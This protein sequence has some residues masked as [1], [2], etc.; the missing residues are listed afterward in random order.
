M[1]P[2]VSDRPTPPPAA[3]PLPA[4]QPLTVPEAP[5]V[6]RSFG[7]T[8]P[9]RV[10]SGNEDHFL[11][12]DLSR[13]LRVQHTSLPQESVHQGRHR[14]HVLLA[15]DGMGGHAAGEV[16]SALSVETVKAFVIDLLRRFTNLQPIDEHGVVV[17]LREAVRQADARII[18][19][20]IRRPE[21]MGMGTTLVLAFISGR[22]L[23]VL[24]AG[25]SRCYLFRQG[26]LH[27]LTED[28]TLVAELARRGEI[29]PEDVRRHPARHVVTNVLGGGRAGVWID[30]QRVHL[31]AGDVVLLCTD[32]LTDMLEDDQIAAVLAAETDP[33][34]ACAR[35]IAQANEAGGNDN[36]TAV[37]A[38]L[39]EA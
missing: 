4:T 18:E 8:D 13:I 29:R 24:Y 16:A 35:L 22:Q 31:E 33:P 15:A 27:H 14:G 12:A 32:G 34:A 6:V 2:L 25:D 19:E 28:H 39:E 5:L 17:D 1:P 7:L 23:F 21:L 38:R 11:I 9:G 26:Q 30:V 10:R 37:V 36:I 20:S 3:R